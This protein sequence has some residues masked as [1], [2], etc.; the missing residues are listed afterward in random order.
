MTEIKKIVIIGCGA[1][2]GTAAQFARKT[3]RKVHITILEQGSYPQYSKCG[4]P[5]A[6]SGDIPSFH[7]LIEF[8]EEW[9]KKS[10][11]D[12][13]LNTHV[14]TVDVINKKISAKKGNENITQTYDSLIIATGAKPAIPP[15]KNI[16][17]NGSLIDNVFYLRTIHNAENISQK[18]DEIKK[19]TV[20]GAGLIGLEMADCLHKKGKQITII[21][22][23]PTILPNILDEDM[24]HPVHET[25]SKKITIFTN[26]LAEEIHT[27]NGSPYA[28]TIKNNKTDEKKQ[29]ETDLILLATGTRP[30]ITL[31][32]KI[33][34]HIGET[35]GIKVNN[36]CETSVQNVYAVGDCTEYVD[37]VT[38]QPML[39]GLGSIAVRQGIA[40]GVNAAGGTYHLP[41]GFLQTCTSEF[42][43]IEIASVGPPLQTIKKTLSVVQAKY[44]GTSLPDYFPG[45]KPISVKVTADANNGTIIKGQAV[46]SNAAQRINTIACAVLNQMHVETLRKLETAYA[47]PIAPTLDAVTIV[48]DIL[49]MK[50]KRKKMG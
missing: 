35:G 28:L 3:N 17:K 29:I 42:F 38:K 8:S 32:Q 31:A 37:F 16:T 19:T 9:F 30:E 6:I 40:A 47:P 36:K 45:G 34:C 50:L 1:A 41:D 27:S 23:L 5:Y 12:L 20:I 44:N 43:G 26:H 10:H 18:L 11:I 33:G 46:G 21:E 22:A 24:S 14:E 25:L 39:V 48:C 7:H 2:G 4:L 15:I 49:S 13:H